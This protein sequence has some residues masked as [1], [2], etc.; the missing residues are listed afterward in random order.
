MSS[1]TTG[2]SKAKLHV[3]HPLEGGRNV[4]MK[5]LGH[6]TKMGAI[7]VYGKNI[8]KSSFEPVDQCQ[9]NL[10]C[11]IYLRLADHSLYKS[12]PWV[13]LDLFYSMVRFGH[14]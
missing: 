6:M 4:Y 2:P 5:G 3:E 14:I 10:V 7:P 13:D 8:K 9:Q 12:S 1:E 11:S